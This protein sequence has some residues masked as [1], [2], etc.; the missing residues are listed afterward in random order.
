MTDIGYKEIIDRIVNRQIE[1]PKDMTVNELAV[2][3]NAYAKCQID[4][5]DIIKDIQEGKEY[6][7]R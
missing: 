4:I 6:H 2:W 1:P 5:I 7:G 3:M